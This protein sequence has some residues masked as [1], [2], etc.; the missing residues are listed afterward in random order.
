MFKSM[1]VRAVRKP[2]FTLS[3][4][5]SVKS[6]NYLIDSTSIIINYNYYEIVIKKCG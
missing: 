6:Y 1:T 3:D 5:T 2:L 4:P